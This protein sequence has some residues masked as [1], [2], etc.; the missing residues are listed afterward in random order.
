[1]YRI[2]LTGQ[3]RKDIRRLNPMLRKRIKRAFGK[4]AVHPQT[5]YKLRGE[6]SGEWSYRVGP[7]RIIYEIHKKKVIVLILAIGHRRDIY[8]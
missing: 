6:H 4:L 3:A 8:R 1:M 2:E 7:C 5:G